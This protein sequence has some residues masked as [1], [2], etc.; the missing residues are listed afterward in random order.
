MFH[1]FEKLWLVLIRQTIDANIEKIDLDLR[2]Y[3]NI[4]CLNFGTQSETS[5]LFFSVAD[6]I[7]THRHLFTTFGG[8]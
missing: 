1:S 7:N 8:Q 2:N 5:V 4:L 3:K 6:A